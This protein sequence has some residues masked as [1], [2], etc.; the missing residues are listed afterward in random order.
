MTKEVIESWK[1]VTSISN[2]EEVAGK[3]LYTK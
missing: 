3:I 2:Y 1:L